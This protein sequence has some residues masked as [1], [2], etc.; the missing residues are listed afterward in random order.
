MIM[1]TPLIALVASMALVSAAQADSKFYG[2]MNVT[3]GYNDSAESFGVESNASRVGIKGSEELASSKLIYQAEYQIDVD[4]D[5]GTAFSQRDTYIGLAY[6]S[7]GTVKMGIMDTPLKKSQGKYDLFNDIVDIKTVVDGE[8]RIAN[9]VNYTTAMTGPFQASL[10]FLMAEGAAT[11]GSDGISANVTYKEGD[12]YAAVAL[13]DSVPGKQTSN[14]RATVIYSLGDMR[15]GGILNKVDSSD[16]ADGEVAI[17]ANVS[18]KMGMNT[19]KAQF[20]SGDQVAA[21]A[22]S[23]SLGVDRKLAKSTKAFAY[24]NQFDA[25]AANSDL[26]VLAVGLEHK[27]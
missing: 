13:D 2:K 20:E 11:K 27:F 18:F 9:S 6:K 24:L 26:L 14:L 23:L 22:T 3:A 19:L 1:K 25:D 12:V 17:G 4:G 5:A 7:M 10:S 15:I 8:N 21:G 16:T